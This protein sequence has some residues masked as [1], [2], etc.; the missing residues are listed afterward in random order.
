MNTSIE[1]RVHW[2][3]VK[4]EKQLEDM[5]KV[6]KAVKKVGVDTENPLIHDNL[7]LIQIACRD[8]CY[9]IRRKH[10]EELS[11]ELLSE[12]GKA[13]SDKFFVF[14]D[15]RNDTIKLREFISTIQ[16]KKYID[17]QLVAK[18]LGLEA[19]GSDGKPKNL[20]SLSDCV[21]HYYGKELNKKQQLSNWG[22]DGE[23]SHEQCRYAVMDAWILLELL[24]NAFK[25]D[26]QF[27]KVELLS[28]L[29]FAIKYSG[30]NDIID[31]SN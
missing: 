9:L 5:I 11:Q 17:V 29:R 3:L 25:K 21:Q 2:I 23:L 12:L 26:E 20:I 24:L 7:Q 31:Y 4:N 14:F 8:F 28:A 16:I 27:T 30:S 15:A 1:E 6:V 18:K 22:R 13:L 10:I 19:F